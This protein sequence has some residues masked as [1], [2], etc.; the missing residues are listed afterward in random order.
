MPR[1]RQDPVRA[2]NLVLT[3]GL[4]YPHQDEDS[5]WFD[6][7]RPRKYGSSSVE[8]SRMSSVY[9]AQRAAQRRHQ[10]Q[11]HQVR[12]SD[13]TVHPTRACSHVRTITK[14]SHDARQRPPVDTTIGNTCHRPRPADGPARFDVVGVPRPANTTKSG[15]ETTDQY[16]HQRFVE[17][18]CPTANHGTGASPIEPSHQLFVACSKP[19]TL[20][21]ANVFGQRSYAR[22]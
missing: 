13:V 16:D 8:S 19:H 11:P 14:Q 21:S 6:G 1:L 7:G 9:Q 20:N 3:Q 22:S 10:G 15:L 17:S 5:T 18:L 4:P 2:S 12:E